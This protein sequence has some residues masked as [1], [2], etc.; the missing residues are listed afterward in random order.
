MFHLRLKSEQFFPPFRKAEDRARAVQ[1]LAQSFQ[2]RAEKVEHHTQEMEKLAEKAEHA[3]QV[4]QLRARAAWYRAKANGL[5]QRKIFLI[6]RE[7]WRRI[8]AWN[9]IQKKKKEGKYPTI[10]PDESFTVL[11][12]VLTFLKE[13]IEVRQ[14]M[15]YVIDLSR[16]VSVI[17]IDSRAVIDTIKDTIKVEDCNNYPIPIAITPNG[18]RAYVT[19]YNRK[20]VSVIDTDISEVIATIDV[21]ECRC[22]GVAVAPDGTKVYMTN[23]GIQSYIEIDSYIESDGNIIVIATDGNAVIASIKVEG[24]LRGAVAVTPDGTKIYVVS[25]VHNTSS[26]VLVIATDSL[27]VIATIPVKLP[28]PYKIAITPDDTKLYVIYACEEIVSVIDINSHA[29][30]AAIPVEEHPREIAITPDGTQAYVIHKWSNIVTVIDTNSN[31]VI[32]TIRMSEYCSGVA[33]T[34]DGTQV[35]VTNGNCISIIATSSHKVIATIE[36]KDYPQS[37]AIEQQ[38]W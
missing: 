23:R 20:I 13:E 10:C 5:Y 16:T 2:N 34:A 38:T 21:G 7:E 22:E 3:D 26:Q 17:D 24:A 15:A 31:V 18:T 1:K 19:C 36:M 12:K 33:I 35:Y 27:K 8:T 9:Q 29:E 28:H 6:L 30:I 11:E 14:A 32:A 4:D 25:K 37:V